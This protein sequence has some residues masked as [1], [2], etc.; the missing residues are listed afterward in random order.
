MR[1]LFIAALFTIT[2]LASTGAAERAPD[3]KARSLKGIPDG[4]NSV[5]RRFKPQA[6]IGSFVVNKD[7]GQVAVAVDISEGPCAFADDCSHIQSIVFT[8]PKLRYDRATRRIMLGNQ[9]VEER[10]FF[11]HRRNPGVTLTL[12]CTEKK[13]SATFRGSGAIVYDLFLETPATLSLAAK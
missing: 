9:V 5:S 10:G 13:A 7:N 6:E 11:R 2:A 8:F 12:K 4:S 3:A 1:I